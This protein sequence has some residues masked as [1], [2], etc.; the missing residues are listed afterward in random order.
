M[1]LCR[2]DIDDDRDERDIDFPTNCEAGNEYCLVNCARPKLVADFILEAEPE[3]NHFN[4][5]ANVLIFLV[6]NL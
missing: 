5:S 2:D 4:N 6:S 1:S 3:R